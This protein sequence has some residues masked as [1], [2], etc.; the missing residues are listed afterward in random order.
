M[1]TPAYRVL[2]NAVMHHIDINCIR[3]CKIIIT[4]I[5]HVVLVTDC[6]QTAEWVRCARTAKSTLEKI[7]KIKL[8]YNNLQNRLKNKIK[9]LP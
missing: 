9:L 1:H 2:A 7:H 5:L 4:Y 3:L 6:G 8:N